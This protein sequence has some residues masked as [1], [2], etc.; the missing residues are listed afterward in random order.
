MKKE[1]IIADIS[2][3]IDLANQNED[4]Y[5][6]KYKKSNDQEYLLNSKEYAN[7]ALAY[8]RVID[9]IIINWKD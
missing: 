8:Q 2:R 1:K 9:L 7:Q 4:Y 6:E 5:F 3:L